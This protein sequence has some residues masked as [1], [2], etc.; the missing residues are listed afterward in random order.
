[1]SEEDDRLDEVDVADPD[2]ELSGGEND[3]EPRS[4]KRLDKLGAEV[5][6]LGGHQ[7]CRCDP[8]ESQ[9][10]S[11][12]IEDFLKIFDAKKSAWLEDQ[13]YLDHVR[14]LHGQAKACPECINEG[15]LERFENTLDYM[16][17]LPD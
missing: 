8:E 13:D 1:M 9:G 4:P 3:L 17:L 7:P 10:I 16:K 14:W 15:L 5:A 2:A 11:D 12:Q 6:D